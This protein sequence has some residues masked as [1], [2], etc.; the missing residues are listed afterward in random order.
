M[1]TQ[2]KLYLI[3]TGNSENYYFSYS[4]HVFLKLKDN[5]VSLLFSSDELQYFTAYTVNTESS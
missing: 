3:G 4:G 1:L 5:S 2:R